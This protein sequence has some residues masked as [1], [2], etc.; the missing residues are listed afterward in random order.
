MLILSVIEHETIWGGS[1][2]LQDKR[3]KKKIGHLYSLI[4]SNEMSSVILNGADAG[5][6]L[7]DYF[8]INKS[9]WEMSDYDDFP[10][11]VALVEA[12]ENLSVQ[13]HPDDKS[14]L[15]LENRQSGK[16]ESWYFLEA[17]TDGYIYNG[18]TCK[19]KKDLR[20][21]IAA[22]KYSEITNTLPVSPGDYV[23]VEAGTLHALTS[24]SFVYEVEENCNLTYRFY[25]YDRK[26]DKGHSRELHT[27]KAFQVIDVLKK[28][29]IRQ[30][31][32][33]DL[34]VERHYS[35]QLL[36]EIVVYE[37]TGEGLAC[38]TV[39]EG[40]FCLDDIDIT[41]GMSILLMPGEKFSCNVKT[42]ITNY[43]N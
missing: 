2:L 4:T 41:P 10:F 12:G 30:Y 16:N 8:R 32:N 5:I 35:T 1:K 40:R 36:R 26:D 25:D 24:G 22:K 13:V 21:K 27:E 7:R 31:T 14:A 29:N 38:F 39:I 11:V 20:L 19:N 15:M 33:T 43:G 18:C 6:T 23:Y 17:P 37:N 34:I 28:S 9:D 3:K 42:G